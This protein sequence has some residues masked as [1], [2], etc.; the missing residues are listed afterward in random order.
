MDEFNVSARFKSSI[1]FFLLDHVYI[2]FD[3]REG[4]LKHHIFL[5]FTLGESQKSA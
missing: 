1:T 5:G 2:Y 3:R 4:N